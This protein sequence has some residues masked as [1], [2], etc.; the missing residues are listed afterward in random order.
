M[1][2]QSDYLI[3]RFLRNKGFCLVLLTLVLGFPLTSIQGQTYLSGKYCTDKG[4]NRIAAC[5]GWVKCTLIRGRLFL[6]KT[7]L[8]YLG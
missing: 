5:V 4:V 8:I 6:Q 1:F 3:Q 2:K 7:A